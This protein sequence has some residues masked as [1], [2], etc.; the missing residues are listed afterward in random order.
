MDDKYFE[1]MAT[2]ALELIYLEKVVRS[3]SEK[4]TLITVFKAVAKDAVEEDRPNSRDLRRTH[5]DI[6]DIVVL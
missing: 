2:D 6:T 4:S 1:K 3:G 5:D